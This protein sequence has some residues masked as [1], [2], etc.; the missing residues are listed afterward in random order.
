MK[1]YKLRT[2]YGSERHVKDDIKKLLDAWGAFWWMP[3]ANGFGKVGVSDINALKRGVFIAVEAKFGGNKPTINQKQYLQ[4]IYAEDG[5]G[6]VVDEKTIGLFA[7]WLAL[8]ETAT[9]H[10]SMG[11]KL[12]D[13]V[14]A[15]LLNIARTLTEPTLLITGK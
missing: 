11:E 15:E 7:K 2:T 3:P 9:V 4:S 10:T 14:G 6:F 12:P 13:A 8:F 1:P 5:F